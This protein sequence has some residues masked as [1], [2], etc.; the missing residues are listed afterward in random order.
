MEAVGAERRLDDAMSAV[1]D[2]TDGVDGETGADGDAD[3]DADGEGGDVPV[4]PPV[5]CNGVSCDPGEECCVSISPT[6]TSVGCVVAGTCGGGMLTCDEGGD[7]PD[8]QV[9][10]HNPPTDTGASC[11][12]TCDG[13]V[14]CSAVGDCPEGLAYCCPAMGGI[15]SICRATAC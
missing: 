2:V 12:T 3:A 4:A 5:D 9:C 7:C 10:C 8:G 11:V 1:P 15:F 6:S 13:I 14:V